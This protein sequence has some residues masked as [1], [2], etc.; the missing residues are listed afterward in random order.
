MFTIKYSCQLLPNQVD[1]RMNYNLVSL[2]MPLKQ[3]AQQK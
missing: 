2:T 3:R 1:K